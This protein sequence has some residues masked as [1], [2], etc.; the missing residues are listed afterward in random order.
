MEL[1]IA[2]INS[3]TTD[4]VAAAVMGF[5]PKETTTFVR[6]RKAGMPPLSRKISKSGER[7]SKMSGRIFQDQELCNGIT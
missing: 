2:G 6:A 3:L 5:Q 1:I 7:L 4:M